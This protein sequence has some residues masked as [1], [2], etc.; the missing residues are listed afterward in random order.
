MWVSAY[1]LAG[2]NVLVELFLILLTRV[3]PLTVPSAERMAWSTSAL[4]HVAGL[5]PALVRQVSLSTHEGVR[6]K[7]SLTGDS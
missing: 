2:V 7:C 3:L 4:V 5:D 6:V 1:I